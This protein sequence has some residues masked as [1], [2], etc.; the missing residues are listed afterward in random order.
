MYKFKVGSKGDLKDNWIQEAE[1]R[2]E[3]HKHWDPQGWT[4]AGWVLASDQ[5]ISLFLSTSESVK[6]IAEKYYKLS[7]LISAES[8]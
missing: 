3:S 2:I 1:R 7:I 4:Q 5:G 8:L 6:K